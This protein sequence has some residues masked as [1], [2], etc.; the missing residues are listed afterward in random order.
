[1]RTT[2]VILLSLLTVGVNGST[3]DQLTAAQRTRVAGYEKALTESPGNGGLMCG[4]AE[5]YAA[6]GQAREAVQWL[7][8]AIDTGIALDLVHNPAFDPIRRSQEFVELLPRAA[9]SATPQVASVLAFRTGE[10]DLEPEGIAYD[11]R[12]RCFYLGSIKQRKIIR[13]EPGGRQTDFVASGK[14]GLLGVVGLRVDPGRRH[15]WANAFG[16]EGSADEGAG[17][18]FQFDLASGRL[19]KKVV[20]D[21][22]NGKHLFNDLVVAPDGAV[23]VTDSEAGVIYRLAPGATAL[24]V[25]AGESGQ[26]R[27]LNG[28]TID[29]SGRRLYVSDFLHGI[30]VLDIATRRIVTVARDLA[31]STYGLDGLYYFEGGLVGI[32]NAVGMARVLRYELDPSGERIVRARVLE[33]SNPAYA[34]PMT[35][36]IVD[37]DLYFVAIG[38]GPAQAGQATVVHRLPLS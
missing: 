28:I 36:A 25:F 38:T 16:P 32:Q 37:R 30:S 33:R 7:A 17:G 12:E 8:R 29:P 2:A 22:A 9:A 4:L 11:P 3:A 13:I 1:M 21:A 20:L 10:K 19:L 23:F 6:G 14:D 15:L 35:G 34:Q 18:L 31:V 27:F 5:V 26:Y 24:E